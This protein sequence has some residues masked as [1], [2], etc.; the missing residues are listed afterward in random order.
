MV[1]LDLF[2]SKAFR[3]AAYPLLRLVGR[4]N[5]TYKRIS[6]RTHLSRI[7][8]THGGWV[9]PTDLL[10]AD[11]V[12]YCVGCGE[13]ITFDIGLIERFGCHVYAFDPTPRAIKHVRD[14]AGPYKNYHF[15][16]VGVWNE[17]TTLKFYAPRNPAHVAH[18]GLNLQ[19]TREFFY[20]RVNTLKNLMQ[21]NEHKALDL[22][23]LDIEGAEYVVVDSIIRDRIDIS[24][25]CIEF[26][27][28]LHP[29][30]RGYIER[31]ATSV[32]ALS[33]A[34]YSLVSSEGNGN[35]SFIR[36]PR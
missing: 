32:D 10:N 29:M 13:D 12:C 8:S 28:Y 36:D 27:E 14:H 5:L 21:E 3:R 30:D 23:K 16:D 9:V 25:L 6:P 35:Y 33:R 4:D 22:L 17:E 7:G 31:I 1:R 19:K 20:A 34:G 2:F 26:D 24:I 18:S 15:L 11:S